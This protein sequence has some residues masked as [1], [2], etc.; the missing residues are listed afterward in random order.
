M[1]LTQFDSVA[2]DLKLLL[3][4]WEEGRAVLTRNIEHER[5][6]E[7]TPASPT[8]DLEALTNVDEHQVETS[9]ALKEVS[10]S[11]ESCISAS[12]DGFS[13]EI[14]EAVAAPRRKIDLTRE[15][16]IEI[17]KDERA[18]TAIAKSKADTSTHM[19]KE[20]ETVIKRRHGG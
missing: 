16:R 5:P 3:Q 12:R 20:L 7:V 11:D 17:M 19:L 8:S 2:K 9:T 15:Q 10:K 4:E 1:V 18:K 13:E 6:L 14:F